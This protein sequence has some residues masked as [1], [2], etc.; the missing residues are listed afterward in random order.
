MPNSAFIVFA[1]GSSVES[2][3]EAVR[4]VAREMA[5]SGGY[6][7][8]E[9]AFLEGGKPDLADA[10][11]AVAARGADRVIVVPYF[12]TLGLHLKRDLPKLVEEARANHPNLNIEVTPPLDGHPAMVEALLGRAREAEVQ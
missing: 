8:V 5:A 7:N 12:L 3:N 9:A 4:V 2:A 10:V 1:H 6:A 11:N